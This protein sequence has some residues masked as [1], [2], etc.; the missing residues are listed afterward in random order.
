MASV[1]SICNRALQKLGANR[2][3]AI[4]DD[5]KSAKACNTVYEPVRDSLLRAHAWGFSIARASLAAE[6]P[7]PTWG[8]ANSFPL[9]A[10]CLRIL[11][12]Y[13][14]DNYST[15]DRVIE[16][17]KILTDESS[18]LY[19]RYVKKVTDPS[20]M[21]AIFCELLST[22]M[23]FEMCEELTQS[24]SKKEALRTDVKEILGEARR[25]N[26]FENPSGDLPEDD[27][28]TARQ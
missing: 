12:P 21:D 4:S 15:I 7:A 23:A 22:R 28:I 25:I 16:G 6:S 19:L 13:P 11:P 26:A 20:E 24:N 1:V 10:D 14:E 18:P 9:P 5:T 27:W 8:R 3:Q 17:R 2:I